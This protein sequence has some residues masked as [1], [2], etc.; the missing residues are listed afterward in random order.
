[1]REPSFTLGV[2]EEYLLVE[3]DSG[4]LVDKLPNPMLSEC[5][6]LAEGQQVKPEFLRSQIEIGTRIC[7]NVAEWF[8]GELDNGADDNG[9]DVRDERGF[10]AQQVGEMLTI[11]IALVDAQP[12]GG[13]LDR[14][15]TTSVRLKN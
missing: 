1:M 4:D 3:R 10:N 9:N 5:E 12:G 13:T 15:I 2:E 6:A 11:R 7:R 14:T 8:P